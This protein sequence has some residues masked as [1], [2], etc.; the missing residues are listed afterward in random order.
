M[1]I[2]TVNSNDISNPN[3][4]TTPL[5]L[6]KLTRVKFDG[7]NESLEQL[8]VT[9]VSSWMTA[10]TEEVASISTLSVTSEIEKDEVRFVQSFLENKY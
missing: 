6:S 10:S 8:I 1:H 7:G 4:L 9:T 2:A 5:S 3:V